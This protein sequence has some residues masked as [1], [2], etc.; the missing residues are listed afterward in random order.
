M[1][2]VIF[3]GPCPFTSKRLRQTTITMPSFLHFHKTEETGTP[4][5]GSLRRADGEVQ[6]PAEGG[7]AVGHPEGPPAHVQPKP[8]GE[9]GDGPPSV[10]LEDA[11]VSDRCDILPHGWRTVACSRIVPTSIFV[12]SLFQSCSYCCGKCHFLLGVE[13]GVP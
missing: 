13:G 2:E 12:V 8:R 1:P 6:G 10:C 5:G 4:G 9:R 3:R 7:G 11:Q